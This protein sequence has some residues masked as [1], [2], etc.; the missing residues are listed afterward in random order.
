MLTG[1]TGAGAVLAGS[2][3]LALRRRRQ[4]QFRARRPGRTIAVPETAIV[5]VEKT[6]TAIGSTSAPTVE[7]MDTL[8]RQLAANITNSNLTMP[9]L[10]AVE[11]GGTQIVLHL[12]A[13]C[14][15]PDP[16]DGTADQLHWATQVGPAV[17]DVD[18]NQPA[19]YPLLVTIGADDT[20]DHVWLLNMEELASINLTGDPTYTR[21]FA[22]YIVAELALNPW[23]AGTTVD[24]IGIADEVAPLN[25]ERIRYRDDSSDAAAEAVADA[26]AMIDRADAQHVDV[27][28]GRG[29][30]ADEDV[31]PARLLLVDATADDHAV[32][33]LIGLVEQHPGKTGTAI[34]VSGDQH[35]TG[36]TVLNLSSS[37]RLTMPRAGLDL[38]AVGL[39]GDEAKGCATLLAHSDILDDIEIPVDEDATEG[40][41]AFTNEAGALREKHTKPRADRDDETTQSVLAG[42]DDEYVTAAATT[43]ED[44]EALAPQ[45]PAEVRVSVESADP[46]LD[47]DVTAWLS[48]DCPLPRLTLLGPVRARAKGSAAAVAKR[49]PYATELLAYLAIRP[50]GATPAQL[51]DAFNLSD[52]RARND[53][54]MVRDWLGTNPRT[55]NKHL[56]NARESEAAK[57]RGVGVYVVEDILVDADLFRRLRAR[58]E[59]RGADGITDLLRAL[60]LVDGRPFDQ[61]RPGGWEWL[62]EGDRLDHHMNAAIVDVAHMVTTACLGSNDLVR[63]RAA[64]EIATAVAPDSEIAKLDLVA[65]FEA[66][67]HRAEAKRIL[68][69]EV[70][71]R[72]DDQGAPAELSARTEKIIRN[73]EWLDPDRAAS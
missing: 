2:A 48:D 34:V 26:V 58:G 52:G 67:G 44:L 45:V 49:K 37:G 9:A 7:Q 15:L 51:A 28:T 42:D 35:S 8:L 66:E 50:H 68:Q 61:L 10:A 62:A 33:Q 63:A 11:L 12:S 36:G 13:P 47:D 30:A 31:W 60:Q 38:V 25:P 27:A 18:E 16:W 17:G 1:L 55:G 14:A 70:C 43:E 73:H 5:P 54:K 57:A 40:W 46:T 65:V 3:L 72:S 29:T 56:P 19:P 53:I 39:T 32:D 22:R 64:A 6:I 4:A 69:D 20:S 21:D 23:S 59:A 24:C 71:N 41:R